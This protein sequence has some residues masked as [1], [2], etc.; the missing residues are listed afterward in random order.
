[1]P[2]DM[3][4]IAVVP[5][6]GIKSA[7]RHAIVDLLFHDQIMRRSWHV[8]SGRRLDG[9]SSRQRGG[10]AGSEAIACSGKWPDPRSLGGYVLMLAGHPRPS[11]GYDV[12]HINFD[13]FDNRLSNLRWLPRSL[14]RSRTRRAI[15]AQ[16][17]QEAAA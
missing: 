3:D 17:S 8:I 1:M 15:L 5:L 4:N 11:D 16:Q 14:N 6:R 9:T 10:G 7:G 2:S 12:D 13:I